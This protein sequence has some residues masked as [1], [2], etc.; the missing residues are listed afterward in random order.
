LG[1]IINREKKF[2]KRI[3]I[4]AAN[5]VDKGKSTERLKRKAMGLKHQKC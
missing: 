3:N 1:N 4:L 2:E 5:K